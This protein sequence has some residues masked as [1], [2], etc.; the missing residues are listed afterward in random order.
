MWYQLMGWYG[1]FAVLA[2]YVLVTLEYFS[3]DSLVYLLLNASGAGALIVQSWYIKNTQLVVLNVVWLG[4]A[5]FALVQL[6][7]Q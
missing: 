4:V 1:V 5:G 6:L 7:L 3:A 2:A